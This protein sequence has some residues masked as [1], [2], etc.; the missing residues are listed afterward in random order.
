MAEYL[1]LTDNQ[2]AVIFIQIVK[3]KNVLD[4]YDKAIKCFQNIVELEPN[5]PEAYKEI[6]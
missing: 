3:I 5:N 4:D 6:I 2:K 1:Q